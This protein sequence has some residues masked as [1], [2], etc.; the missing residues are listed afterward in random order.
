MSELILGKTATY[1]NQYNPRLLYAVTRQ[2]NRNAL[3]I[4]AETLPFYGEDIWHAYELS[5]LNSKGKPEVAI[6]RFTFPC[7]TPN[8]VE[9]KS[10]KLYLNSLNNTLFESWDHV[11]ATIKRDLS[12]CAGGE[13]NIELFELRNFAPHNYEPLCG[14]CL[15]DLDI[16]INEYEI[17]TAYLTTQSSIV[18]ETL[19]S[20]LLKSN[21]L[22]TG[23]P[24]WGAVQIQYE[25][26][27]IH[28]ENLLRYIVSF[29]N[30]N[31]FHEQC[32][33]RIYT[34]IWRHCAPKSLTVI[35]CYTRRG[36]LDINPYRTS[37]P[38]NALTQRR[39]PRQ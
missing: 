34:D 32:V 8:L 25:G 11:M 5:W 1:E 13:V 15:D 38:A 22:V 6:G 28:R 12:D 18:S 37:H 21:C 35:A 24:D 20:N 9:S 27:Q 17:N 16:E 10:L 4:T 30:H 33:E 2:Q 26:A 36:G 39:C 23:Q 31:E 3:G 29:R 14:I 7:I 19:Y